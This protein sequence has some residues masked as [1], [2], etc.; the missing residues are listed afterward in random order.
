MNF[1]HL[2]EEKLDINAISERVADESC[3]AISLFVGTTRDHFDDKK[4]GDQ[5]LEISLNEQKSKKKHFFV[6][7]IDFVVLGGVSEV[8]GL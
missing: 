6:D 5:S 4:V 1:I 3:G 7:K 2:T 8:R